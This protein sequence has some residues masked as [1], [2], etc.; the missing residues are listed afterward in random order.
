MKFDQIRMNEGP[1]I[2]V[3]ATLVGLAA[4]LCIGILANVFSVNSHRANIAI[5][6][7]WFPS[8]EAIGKIRMATYQVRRAEVRAV[9]EKSNCGSG[10]CESLLISSRN[11]LNDAES[12][13][14]PLISEPD[15]ALLYKSYQLQ[16][17]DYLISQ[18]RVIQ[19]IDRKEAA[20]VKFITNS[21]TM[22][23]QMLETLNKISDLNSKAGALAKVEADKQHSNLQLALNSLTIVLLLCAGIMLY[24][25]FKFST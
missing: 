2:S 7:N 6:T 21:Q 1:K 4:C 18:D 16:K 20:E 25:L 5:A 3:I 12:A 17:Y 9:M 15:E 23:D 13:Y 14:M 22:F 11:Q 10:S 8:V 19:A 24:S